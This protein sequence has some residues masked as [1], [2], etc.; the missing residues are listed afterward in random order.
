MLQTRARPTAPSFILCL[1][2]SCP[3]NMPAVRPWNLTVPL[4]WGLD[5][6]FP[7][8]GPSLCSPFPSS[9]TQALFQVASSSRSL[10]PAA[11]RPGLPR[12]PKPCLSEEALTESL[13]AAGIKDG[14]LLEP[15]CSSHRT[16]RR[17]SEEGP[18]DPGS[19]DSL[20]EEWAGNPYNQ[21]SHLGRF[22]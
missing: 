9:F 21:F 7:S 4:P 14:S 17:S 19:W 8:A 13:A 1:D 22:P 3:A 6:S 2:T 18:P 12:C 11:P 16:C 10:P 20:R 5:S 15:A